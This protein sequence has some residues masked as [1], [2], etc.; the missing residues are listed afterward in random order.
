MPIIEEDIKKLERK[1]EVK[2]VVLSI[3]SK[4]WQDIPNKYWCKKP[5]N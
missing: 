2:N 4:L 3:I 5:V 1:D